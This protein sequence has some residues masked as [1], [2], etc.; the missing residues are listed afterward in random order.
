MPANVWSPVFGYDFFISYKHGSTSARYAR[1]LRDVL[2]RADK[3]CFLDE[4]EA[5][6]GEL[7]ADVIP[8][9]LRRSRA[10]LL[11]VTPEALESDWVRKEVREFLKLSRKI[12]PIDLNG[13]FATSQTYPEPFDK[14][15]RDEVVWLG[16]T[17]GGIHGPSDRVIGGIERQIDFR[18]ANRNRRIALWCV[19]GSL[20]VLSGGLY[21]QKGE[22]DAQRDRA[23]RSAKL[24]REKQAEASE[25][26]LTASKNALKADLNAFQADLNAE[27]AK[28]KAEEARRQALEADRQKREATHQRDR[29]VSERTAALSSYERLAKRHSV[30]LL[31][32]VESDRGSRSSAS[33]RA[34]RDVLRDLGT[35]AESAQVFREGS[36]V[37]DLSIS[38]DGIELVWTT[39]D[40]AVRARNLADTGSSVSTLASGSPFFSARYSGDGSTLV[41]TSA[42][43]V[44]RIWTEAAAGRVLSELPGWNAHELRDSAISFDG[45][46]VAVATAQGSVDVSVVR[47]GKASQHAQCNVNSIGIQSIAF[48][49]IGHELWVL[50]RDGALLRWNAM[51]GCP[52]EADLLPRLAGGSGPGSAVVRAMAFFPAGDRLLLGYSD[53]SFR[54]AQADDLTALAPLVFPEGSRSEVASIAIHPDLPIAAASLVSGDIL[55]WSEASARNG[56]IRLLG[57][58][59]SSTVAFQPRSRVLYSGGSDGTVRRWN[60][61]RMFEE[62][63]AL[64]LPAVT[65]EAGRMIG[66]SERV[67]SLA[68]SPAMDYVLGATDGG[69][70]IGWSVKEGRIGAS[71]I[72][73]SLQPGSRVL[74]LAT[75]K[76]NGRVALLGLDGAIRV[77]DP[78]REDF[79]SA[80]QL[81]LERESANVV[82]MNGDGGAVLSG[83]PRSKTCY[84][85]LKTNATPR[86]AIVPIK[87]QARAIAWTSSDAFAVVADGTDVWKLNLAE[88]TRMVAT[89]LY[90]HPNVLSIAADPKGRFV[91]SGSRD[92]TVRVFDVN[93]SGRVRDL[94]A[95]ADAFLRVR[96]SEDGR[97]IGAAS[98]S[99]KA[100]L[101]EVAELAKEPISVRLGGFGVDDLVFGGED[102][103]LITAWGD[104]AV[105]ISRLE[106]K[107][108]H[109]LACSAAGRNMTVAEWCENLPRQPYRRTC[110]SFPAESRE[111]DIPNCSDA[112]RRPRRGGQGGGGGTASGQTGPS[113]AA[114]PTQ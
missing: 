70:L 20:S 11:I 61:D 80:V 96:V 4:D 113:A 44:L 108:L 94:R 89:W 84:W 3:V 7:L 65:A 92:G 59:R 98:A 14:L 29:A 55:V 45:E 42:D 48:R 47:A 82:A 38:P 31:L 2:E 77:W 51:T 34:L 87:G 104:G 36:Y 74:G 73:A 23:E 62:P 40:G 105:L 21:W 54:V 53:G 5:P 9:G 26:A 91:V 16:E 103:P 86:C 88:E 6:A 10:M 60:L 13:L 58:V 22:A 57:H 41:T 1:A 24:A 46:V 100:V 66:R 110:A 71:K 81:R 114:R 83:G 76:V 101:W 112:F 64:S 12:I 111:G 67:K 33:D 43:G 8:R 109:T 17:D 52:K 50:G 32:A 97:W 72:L 15:M 30:A 106:P 49:P 79:R 69:R 93:R 39:S 75:A 19:V 107:D 25:N 37:N 95:G 90:R 68:K 85:N 35:I 63:A 99:S 27:E 18:T 78:M 56:P 102:A 28:S